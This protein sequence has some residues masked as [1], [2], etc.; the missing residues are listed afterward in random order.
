MGLVSDFVRINVTISKHEVVEH[1]PERPLNCRVGDPY[2]SHFFST[3]VVEFK[4]VLAYEIETGG[5][6]NHV[7]AEYEDKVLHVQKNL[8]NDVHE[9][10]QLVNQG[11]KIRNLDINESHSEDLEIS[12]LFAV[13]LEVL[14]LLLG[15]FEDEP[16]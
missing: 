9:R 11:Q 10:S 8:E 13:P 15:G 3:D 4:L 1:V 5:N 2:F 7:N 12:Y 14:Y 6:T 16:S